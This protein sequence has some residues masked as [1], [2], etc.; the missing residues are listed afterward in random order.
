MSSWPASES[1][2][3]PPKPPVS[4]S[5]PRSAPPWPICWQNRNSMRYLLILATALGLTAAG[6]MNLTVDKLTAFIRP[7]FN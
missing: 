4:F 2:P 7:P 5:V 1:F 6:E 3:P